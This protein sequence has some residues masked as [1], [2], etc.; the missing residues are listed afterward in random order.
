M[1]LRNLAKTLATNESIYNIVV[2]GKAT[3]LFVV[4]ECVT[5]KLFGLAAKKNIREVL[6]LQRISDAKAKVL[7]ALQN[8]TKQPSSQ[9]LWIKYIMFKSA[10]LY[11]SF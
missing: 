9:I 4:Q 3:T 10:E 7:S 2:R 6:S 11:D 1:I 8:Q 5:T